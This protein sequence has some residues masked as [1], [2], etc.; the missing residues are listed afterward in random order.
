MEMVLRGR[1]APR[2]DDAMKRF[3]VTGGLFLALALAGSAARA[4]TGTAR[5]K[6]MD[7]K[8]QPI[9]D[10]VVTIEYQG[11]VTRKYETKTNKKGE[12]TQVGIYPG[13]YKITV[14]KEGYQGGILDARISLGE[15]T[16]LSDMKLMT[17]S[18]AAAAAGGAGD[19][20][21][22]ELMAAFKSATELTQAGKLDE[23][24][25]AYNAIVAKNATI[26]EVQYNL[27]YI[28]TQKKDWAQAEAAYKKALELKPGYSE[29]NAALLRVYQESGQADKAT[30]LAAVAGNDPKV[31][32]NM[33]VT[34]L[35]SGKYEEAMA[36]FQ[37]AAAAD[38]TNPE[39]YFY[40]G[41]ILVGQN[42]VTDAVTSLEK[43]L[44]M[45]PP[46]AQNVATAQG[47]LQAL[48]PKK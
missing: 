9:V 30:E 29:A 35:N 13:V 14:S 47:L 26:P 19:K 31:Q 24:L 20:A 33:G 42:K 10:A 18:A 43:Y 12:Y 37:K 2:E 38:P 7:D 34:F 17:K 39:P 44:A 1:R 23:A 48:K 8:G 3:F 11:G 36:A 16:Y 46:N 21:R 5:G 45:N 6:I 28:Y 27:G 4:Q 22:E 32:F 25:A 41:T 15:P 40:M